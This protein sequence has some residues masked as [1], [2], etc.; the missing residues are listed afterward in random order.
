MPFKPSVQLNHP[1]S[2]EGPPLTWSELKFNPVGLY[3]LRQRLGFLSQE[4]GIF[5]LYQQSFLAS[6]IAW[7]AAG[8]SE[9]GQHLVN[10]DTFHPSFSIFREN[11]PTGTAG[12]TLR[13][14]LRQHIRQTIFDLVCS[15][16]YIMTLLIRTHRPQC[17]IEHMEVLQWSFMWMA[18]R[19]LAR[20]SF[21]SISRRMFTYHHT[22]LKNNRSVTTPLEKSYRLL[23]RALVFLLS[24]DGLLLHR[25]WAGLW[26]RQDVSPSLR[27]LIIRPLFLI[28]QSLGLPTIFSMVA[29]MAQPSLLPCPSHHSLPTLVR[30]V[31]PINQTC[32]FAFGSRRWEN[33]RAR[34]TVGM[35]IPNGEGIPVGNR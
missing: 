14:N 32:K 34:S 28:L 27:H 12:T 25:T 3:S 10:R 21:Q 9:D 31:I 20:L 8:A 23:L 2:V 22:L 7:F 13:A 16:L 11:L 18:R 29:L 33:L 6:D 26:H 4:P 17:G 1:T 30:Y 19:F 15:F 24:A 35:G 5:K